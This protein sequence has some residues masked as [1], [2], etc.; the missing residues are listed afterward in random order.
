M[1]VEASV[2]FFIVLSLNSK[3][4]NL[5]GNC[6]MFYSYAIIKCFLLDPIPLST[7]N[8]TVHSKQIILKNPD[9][10]INLVLIVIERKQNKSQLVFVKCR[11]IGP[12]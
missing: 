5:T 10:S 4:S 1:T 12:N 11:K 2:Y 7:G 3:E 8:V 9:N 6:K